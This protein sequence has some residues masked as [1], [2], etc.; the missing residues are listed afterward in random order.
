M[1]H[2]SIEGMDGVGKSTICKLLAKELNYIFV[3]KPLHYLYEND[4]EIEIYQSVAKKV[5]ASPNRDFT[6]WYYGLNNLYVYEKF[7][8][9]N[10]ITDRHIVSNYCWSGTEYNQDIYDL[11][12]KKIGIPMIT[13][14]LYA[15]PK[16]IEKRLKKRDSMDL[17]LHK[18]P[19]SE[20]RYKKMISFCEK[21]RMPYFL[22]D[23]SEKNPNEIVKEIIQKIKEL[24]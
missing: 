14:I 16:E 20:E 19:Q 11:I 23:T 9:Q 3:E 22:I 2:I 8:D 13:I 4:D 6:A 21:T 24:L 1:N 7:K 5:N 12:I 17:D 15:N 18:L 10:I